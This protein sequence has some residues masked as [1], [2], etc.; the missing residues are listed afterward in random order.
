LRCVIFAVCPP[1]LNSRRFDFDE[2][3]HGEEA[4]TNPRS[5][6]HA[7]K[8]IHYTTDDVDSFSGDMA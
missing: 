8:V 6:A 4:N 3:L 5:T 7:L 1:D 2:L